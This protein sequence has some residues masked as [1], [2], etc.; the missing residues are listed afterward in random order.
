M[1]NEIKENF[2][3]IVTQNMINDYAIAS[4]D[5]NPIHLDKAF[6]QKSIFKKRIAHGM[7]TLSIIMEYLYK[8]YSKF[9]FDDSSLEARFKNPL[10]ADEKIIISHIEKNISENKKIIKVLCL[11]ENGDEVLTAN[12][13]IN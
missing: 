9:W 2:E 4:K 6:A 3:I 1:E 12:L 10:F 7:L 5:F 11:K 13:T 8:I